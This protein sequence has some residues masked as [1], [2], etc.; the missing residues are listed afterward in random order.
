MCGRRSRLVA[1]VESSEAAAHDRRDT[2]GASGRPTNAGCDVEQTK[3]AL[4][5]SEARYRALF[6]NSSDAIL[7]AEVETQAIRFA[8]PTATRIFGYAESDLCRMCVADLAP[9]AMV[10]EALSEFGE[11]ARG[12][13]ARSDGVQALRADGTVI[14]VDVSVA[15]VSVGGRAMLAGF[16]RDVTSRTEAERALA[17]SEERYRCLFESARDGILILDAETGHIVDVNPYMT[18]LTGYGRDDFIGKALWEIGAFKDAGASK[19][20][21]AQLQATTYIRYDDLPLATRTGGTVEVEFVSNIYVVGGRR[22][23]QCNVRDNTVRKRTEDERRRLMTAIEQADEVVLVTDVDGAIT[24]VNA[25]FQTVTG[26]TRGEVL[27]KNP[28]L[29]KSGTQGDDFYRALWATLAAGK[30]WRGRLVNKK[31]DGSLYSQDA[32]LSPVRDHDGNIA[33]FVGV[34]RD[35]TAALALEAQFLH[36][37][38]MEAVGRLAGGIAHDFNN[39]LS[40]I[41]SYAEVMREDMKPDDPRR[42]DVEEIEKAGLR[43]V[44]LTR[45]LLAFSRR[46]V[47]ETKVLNPNAAI[48]W[49]AKMLRQL[50][51]ADIELATLPADD[52]WN[53]KVDPGQLEQVLMNLAV[54]ARD[55]M[56]HGGKL[57]I[58]T[59]NVTL[60]EAHSTTHPDVRAGDYVQIAVGDSGLG[61]DADTQARI[62][63]PFFTTKE[64]EKGTGLGLATVFG[65]VRQSEGHIAVESEPGVGTTFRIYLPKFG[66]AAAPSPALSKELE[67]A[68]GSETILLVEDEDQVRVLARD[69]LRR[70]GYVVLDAASAGEALLVCEQHEAPIDLL[71]AD[72]VLPRMNGRLLAERIATLRPAIKVLLMSGYTDDAVLLRGVLDSDLAFLQKPLTPTSLARKV[73]EVLDATSAGKGD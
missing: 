57:T 65:I 41:L 16:F 21:F 13:K 73:R 36:A 68:A 28:R 42:A 23:V 15:H 70:H 54:N 30:T 51:G 72:V 56:P 20:S 50:L 2:L 11:F 22:V 64:K 24:F 7:I 48:G 44:E 5:E 18:D 66:G 71:L 10:G 12:A 62:F 4:R 33:S 49:I 9:K 17:R 46:Q 58:E 47:L 14:V 67:A 1:F 25:A 43:A 38:K 8:N 3:L 45:Q 19:A 52:L 53:V 37:Q 55:A 69:V 32:T 63:E 34:A 60:D 27:G 39:V 59:A 40:V 26:Y 61:M 35:V 29:L 31:K 6:E